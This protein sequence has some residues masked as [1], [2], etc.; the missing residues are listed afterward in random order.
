MCS[1]PLPFWTGPI[2]SSM[3]EGPHECTLC[4]PGRHTGPVPGTVDPHGERRAVI[5]VQLVEAVA[6][7]HRA[8]AAWTVPASAAERAEV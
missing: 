7:S 3:R 1:T 6:A 8:D 2:F 4:P 5:G